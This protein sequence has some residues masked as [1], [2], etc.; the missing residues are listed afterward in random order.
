MCFEAP[1]DQSAAALLFSRAAIGQA[2][3]KRDFPLGMDNASAI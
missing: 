1:R 3:P 2:L